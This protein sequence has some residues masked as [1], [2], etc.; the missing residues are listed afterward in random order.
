MYTVERERE[1]ELTEIKCI[2]PSKDF[3]TFLNKNLLNTP[4]GTSNTMFPYV[5]LSI[6]LFFK[7]SVSI[8]KI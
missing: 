3:K 2:T 1:R 8:Y 7:F 6:C 5:F 4:G